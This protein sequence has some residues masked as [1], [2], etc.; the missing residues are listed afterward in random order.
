VGLPIADRQLPISDW[1]LPIKAMG[2]WQSVIGN[3]ENLQP[4]LGGTDLI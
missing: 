4:P 3:Q 1:L 2:N